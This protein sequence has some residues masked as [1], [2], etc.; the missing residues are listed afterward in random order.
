MYDIA[1][2]PDDLEV[3]AAPELVANRED[4]VATAKELFAAVKSKTIKVRVQQTY[5][6]KDVARAHEDLEA[7]LH[8]GV[9]QPPGRPPI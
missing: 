2:D 9:V 6:L 3:I 5:A 1:N 7:M 8:L 4:L